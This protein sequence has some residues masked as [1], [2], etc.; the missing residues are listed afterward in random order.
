MTHRLIVAG[1][2]TGGHVLAGIAIADEWKRQFAHSEIIFV[3]ARGGIEERLVPR[4]HYPLK[5]LDLGAL[6]G[7]SP[8][9]RLKTLLKIPL[10]FVLSIQ[11]LIQFR[12]Q[13]VI[14][15]GGY[16][17]GPLVLM[18][19]LLSPF[20]KIRV[21][22]LEQN[23][24][25]GFT[26]RFLAKFSHLVFTA[27]P[28]PEERL[29]GVQAKVTGNPVRS[30]IQ[31]M[32]SAVVDPFQIFIFGGSQGA[33][34]INTLVMEA[35]PQLKEALGAEFKKIKWVHQTGE[36]DFQRVLDAHTLAGTGARVEKFID[37]MADVYR[38]SRLVICR[39]GSSTLSELAQARRA[40]VMIPF[41]QAT[42]NHQEE[43]AMIFVRAQA[44][45]ILKQGKSTGGDLALI[46]IEHLKNP[47]LVENL[48]RNIAQFAVPNS[49]SVIVQAL[50]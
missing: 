30:A 7:V 28:I 41:P 10:A 2:G 37:D 35:I 26:N 46:I 33:M 47:E 8:V 40:A 9:R 45:Q 20:L 14:G 36:R 17:S 32:P 13:A 19:R 42:D 23:A 38:A 24:V 49:A 21:A 27:F 15:V 12:P 11:W 50:N 39:A 48:Q 25:P 1:G 18:A 16:A 31:P 22:V 4:A 34:G 3:G 6:K 5:V 44:A 43:N 29:P